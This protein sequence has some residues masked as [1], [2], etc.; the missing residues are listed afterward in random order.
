MLILYRI[1]WHF[2]CLFKFHCPMTVNT[3]DE[4]MVGCYECGMVQ[5]KHGDKYVVSQSKK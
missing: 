4:K 2:H 3:S 1:K 5:D